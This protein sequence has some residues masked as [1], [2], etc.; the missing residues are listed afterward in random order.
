MKYLCLLLSFFAISLSLPAQDKPVSW[1]LTGQ[2]T[3]SISGDGVPYATVILK[4]DSIKIFKAMACDGTGKF[5]FNLSANDKYFLTI[6][7]IGYKELAMP[8]SVSEP[9]TSLGKLSMEATTTLKDVEITAQK[10]LVKLDV[11]K[12]V[13]SMEADPEAQ[14]NSTFEMLRKVPLVTV[15]A[16]ENITVNGQSN[17]KVLVNGK[18]SSMMSSNLKDVLKSLP[19]N[20]IRNIEVIT[21]PS[22]KYD[23]EGV[24]GILNII[25]DKKTIDGYNGSISSGVNNRGS[26]NGSVFLTT[27]IKKLSTSLRYYGSQFK[28]PKSENSTTSEYFDNEQYHYSNCGR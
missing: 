9:K 21:N 10:P 7:A 16:E 22:S 25:T 20:T 11:D 12:I 8:V 1:Q 14:T 5:T 19:A 28:Q 13:Y 27:K 6:T 18:S 4:T 2:V 26:I 17:F 3:D 24:G 15:D 23:A